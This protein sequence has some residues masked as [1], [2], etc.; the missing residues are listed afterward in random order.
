MVQHGVAFHYGRMPTLLRE[1][2]ETS[3]RSGAIQYLVCTTTLFQGVNLPARNVFINTPTRGRGISLNAAYLWNFAG[4][5]GRLGQDLVGNVFLVDYHQW[6]ERELNQPVKFKVSPAFSEIVANHFDKVIGAVSGDMPKLNMR[7]SLTGN[8]RAAAGLLLARASSN[9]TSILLERNIGLTSDQRDKLE[10][11]AREAAGAI[12]LPTTV[13]K[14]NWTVDPYGLRRLADRMR[15]KIE[16]G[17]IDELIPIHPDE[18]GAYKRYAGIFSR[19]VREVLNYKVKGYGG[20]I[21]TYAIPWMSGAPYPVL[22]GKWINYQKKKYPNADVND[23]VRKAFDFMEDVLRFQMVQLGKAYI[24]VLRHVFAEFGLGHRSIEIY[25]YSL[26]LELGVSSTSGRAF[27]E[28]GTSRITAL[29]LEALFPDSELT[30]IQARSRLLKLNL[31]AISLS[32][33]IVSELHQLG[34]ISDSQLPD[35]MSY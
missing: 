10:R 21:A 6:K 23:T 7:D 12:R 17:N 31:H 26:T 15:T 18:G 28:L 30:P 22:I 24:D 1:A 32:Q 4:R 2:L 19:L 34:L 3:F 35:Q 9:G 13:L 20:F 29:A 25:D 16:E 11:T 5:A 14:N 33:V 27:I 8:I